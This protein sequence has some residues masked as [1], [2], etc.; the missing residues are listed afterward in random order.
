MPGC[1]T[2][3]TA[4][5]PSG[6]ESAA[7]RTGNGRAAMAYDDTD[8]C[9]ANTENIGYTRATT[10]VVPPQAEGRCNRSPPRGFASVCHSQMRRVLGG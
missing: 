5:P 4:A 1:V 3:R 7:D 8:D 6:L 10:G 9:G 2:E